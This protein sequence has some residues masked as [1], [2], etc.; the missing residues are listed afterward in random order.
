MVRHQKITESNANS[1]Q[2]KQKIP[3]LL[4]IN[5][6][7][8]KSLN[9]FGLS[10]KPKTARNQA[11]EAD[12]PERNFNKCVSVVTSKHA[13]IRKKLR[14]KDSPDAHIAAAINNFS[15][16]R[17]SSESLDLFACSQDAHG[18]LDDP[19]YLSEMR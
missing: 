19:T 17:W 6:E 7:S 18:D 2:H 10:Q 9:I 3:S 4:E 15:P 16:G 11:A 5:F 14:N 12:C 1:E 8:F 13:V